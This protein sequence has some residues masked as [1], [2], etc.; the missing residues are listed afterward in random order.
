MSKNSNLLTSETSLLLVVD[1]QTKLVNAM[2]KDAAEDMLR[3]S[4]HLVKASNLLNIPV[5][6]SEQYPKGLGS[7]VEELTTVMNDKPISFEKTDFSCCSADNFNEVLQKKTRLQ[8]IIAGL[9]THVCILQTAL[10]LVQQGYQVHVIED[11][12]CSRKSEH[13]YYA[14]QRMQ[15]QGITISNTES[16]LFEWLK[17][18]RHEHFTMISQ[19]LR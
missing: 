3:N 16:V 7:T 1:I 9:E 5:L 15:Q 4:S 19:L 8:V 12:V 2:P 17:S 10:D 14:L 6:L 11:A 18:S 13:K